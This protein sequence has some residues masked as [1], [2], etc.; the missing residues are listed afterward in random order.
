[1]RQARDGIALVGLEPAAAFERDRDVTP[2]GTRRRQRLDRQRPFGQ[3]Q[4]GRL[5]SADRGG[6]RVRFAGVAHERQLVQ[7]PSDKVV[8][9]RVYRHRTVVVDRDDREVVARSAQRFVHQRRGRARAAQRRRE[10]RIAQRAREI[11]GPSRAR[12]AGATTSIAPSAHGIANR[13]AVE[14][15]DDDR[16]QLLARDVQRAQQIAIRAVRQAR[17]DDRDVELVPFSTSRTAAAMSA[18]QR[19]SSETS[20]RAAS[21]QRDASAG[22]SAD[23]Q[24]PYVLASSRR[25]VAVHVASFPGKPSRPRRP[26]QNWGMVAASQTYVACARHV[27]RC[28]SPG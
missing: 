12:S 8:A 23:Q 2:V 21:A 14:R 4:P 22:V 11:A 20:S 10:H 6:E 28:A 15:A 26:Y 3:R 16:G 17:R 18:A 5:Q 9:R 1:M 24:N 7:R 25:A 19:R 27:R 13:V